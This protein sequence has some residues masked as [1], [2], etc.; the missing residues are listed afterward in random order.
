MTYM[1]RLLCN[2]MGTTAVA[3]EK[4]ITPER[5]RTNEIKKVTTTTTKKLKYNDSKAFI[6]Y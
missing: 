5:Q 6:D 2:A 3:A 4:K 1:A